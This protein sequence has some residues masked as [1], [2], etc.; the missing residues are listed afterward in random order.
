MPMHSKGLAKLTEEMG[1]LGQVVGKR[2]AY[3]EGPHPDEYREKPLDERMEDEIADVIAACWFVV[4]KWDL[5]RP[6]ISAR[7]MEKKALFAK[8]DMEE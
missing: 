3:P 7:V 5:D 2:Q 4:Q 1:E 6:K 8:W